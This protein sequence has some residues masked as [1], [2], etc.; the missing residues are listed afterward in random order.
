MG[1]KTG[2]VSFK[3]AIG[4]TFPFTGT[5]YSFQDIVGR[6]QPLEPFYEKAVIGFSM[7]GNS[8]TI[9]VRFWFLN[10]A[11]NKGSAWG[12]Q[13]NVAPGGVTGIGASAGLF[14]WTSPLSVAGT[15]QVTFFGAPVFPTPMIMDI[16]RAAGASVSGT[17]VIGGHLWNPE[18]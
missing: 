7:A 14:T 10:P 2:I 16:D 4:L 12:T 13:L 8:G 15:T 3:T 17:L 1:R 6:N 5:T 11:G 9:G 18:G